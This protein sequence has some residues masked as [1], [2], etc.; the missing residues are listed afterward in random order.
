MSRI[1]H[2]LATVLSVMMS[3]GASFGAEVPAEDLRQIQM[4]APVDA[5][6]RPKQPRKVLVFSAADV[7]VHASIPWG[8]QA[9]RILGEKSGA[10]AATLSKDPAMFDRERLFAFDAVVM[11]N[12]CGNPVA[13]ALRRANLLEFVRSGHGLVG[14]HCAAHLDWPEFIDMLGGY[15]IDHPWNEGSTVAIKVNEPQHPLVRCFAGSSF[16]HSDEIFRFGRFSPQKVRVLLSLDT[17][18]TDM[19]KPGVDPKGAFP[20]SWVRPYGQGR[21]FYCELGH[22]KDVYWQ[23]PVLRHYLA[24]IQFALGDLDAEA[25]PRSAAAP[26]EQK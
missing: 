10:Y 15:S 11:N 17:A 22:Q 7:Y 9:M 5:P 24:G 19:N 20:L 13:D 18:W 1:L 3:F 23:P 16:Q 25:T 4:A 26:T 12:N 14:I 8:A 6:A 21:V 2:A